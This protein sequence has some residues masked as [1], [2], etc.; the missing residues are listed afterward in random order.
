MAHS[1]QYRGCT[2]TARWKYA[3]DYKAEQFPD[4]FEWSHPDYDGPPSGLCG[5]GRTEFDCKSDIDDFLNENP[6]YES[7][8]T[9]SDAAR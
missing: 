6:E 2:I 3:S 7:E 1:I 8:T 9:Q 4:S 5:F